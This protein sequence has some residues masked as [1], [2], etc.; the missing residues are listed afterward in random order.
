MPYHNKYIGNH[1]HR[2]RGMTLIELLVTL[3]VL[4]IV[5]ALAFPSFAG[6]LRNNRVTTQANGI[7]AALAGARTE[8]VVRSRSVTIC[9]A[10]VAAEGLPSECGDQEDWSKGWVMFVDDATTAPVAIA[11]ANVI[12]VGEVNGRTTLSNDE[13]FY[14]RFSP[15][16][17]I[18]I[19]GTE[20]IVAPDAGCTGQQRRRIQVNR[21]GRASVT[22]TGCT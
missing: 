19:S 7:V 12:Q 5:V 15:R 20:F 4:A 14:L 17:D 22:R 18:N 10:D 1:R 16:G 6:T 13:G 8:S 21:M 11:P 2:S 3:A 9:A